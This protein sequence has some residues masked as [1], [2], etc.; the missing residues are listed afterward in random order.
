MCLI[1]SN[2]YLTANYGVG[3]RQYLAKSGHVRK[4]VDLFDTKFFG[5]AVL[6][7]ITLCENMDI[8]GCQVEYIGVRTSQKET[9]LTCKD[10][11]KLFEFIE[12]AMDSNKAFVRFG[13]DESKVFEIS[14]SL[15]CI[16][17]GGKTWNFSSGNENDLKNYMEKKAVC[18]LSDLMEICVGIKTT[19]DNVFVKPMTADFVKQNSFEENVIYPLIQSFDVERWRITWGDS[20]KDR[21]ILYP[22][23]ET[24]GNMEA[25][26]LEEIPHAA[27]YLK[28]CADVL[29]KRE[30]LMESKTRMWYECW[31]PQK[32]SKFKQAKI[33]TRDRVSHN[34]FA[35]DADG[36]LCQGNTFFLIKKPVSLYS[37]G[38]LNLDEE[39]Y[40]LFI[41][42]LLNS[43]AMEYYQKM[44]SG[45]LYSQKYRYT[46][47]NLNRW[48][49]PNFD[50]ETARRIASMVR[51]L[52]DR[53]KDHGE[54]E[55]DDQNEKSQI[56]SLSLCSGAARSR[57]RDN[58]DRFSG[59]DYGTGRQCTGAGEWCRSHG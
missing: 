12:K 24:S 44:I 8:S 46:S 17:N 7:A 31:V 29:K 41:L 33:V 18:R 43:H 10:A 1:T 2:K 54:I 57:L 26:P 37:M 56:Y 27:T 23:R 36:R 50:I 14:K 45:C 21:Y 19:A 53:E 4:I 6:P 20:K 25:V 9:A 28:E 59:N 5:A 38:F 51:Q 15:V 58:A 35:Y 3:L 47:T 16:P 40:Y 39:E 52:M 55:E 30:Y 13:Q 34:S 48:P 22:H 42:G 11:S 32:L 49:I